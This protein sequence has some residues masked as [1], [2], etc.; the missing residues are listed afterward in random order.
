MPRDI[1]HISVSIIF[2]GSDAHKLPTAMSLYRSQLD[3]PFDAA[4]VG[5]P[6]RLVMHLSRALG[7]MFHLRDGA[8]QVAATR[9]ALDRLGSG[10]VLLDSR[11]GVQFANVAAQALFLE[12]DKV[13]LVS[14][15]PS[16]PDRLAPASRLPK[17]EQAF[18]RALADAI[19]PVEGDHGEH[20]S[21]ALVLPGVG[22]KP[23]CVMHAAPL[24]AV[25]GL[26]AGGM[27]QPRAIVFFYDLNGATVAPQLLCQLFGMTPAEARAARQVLE[28]GSADDMARRLAVSVNT[29]KTQLKAVFAKTNTN[30]QVDL[31][32]LL[33]SLKAR[34]GSC[35]RMVAAVLL[36]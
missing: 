5:L 29:F 17:V 15:G 9:A 3:Q 12:G 28:G 24:G 19:A 6:R 2:D 4:E 18:Q 35:R 16:Q 11:G 20:F 32:K 22:G 31:L 10:V 33:L 34:S 1:E 23:A 8:Q 21:Q 7:V 27:G 26:S 25:A 14:G 30:R 36:G 13:R